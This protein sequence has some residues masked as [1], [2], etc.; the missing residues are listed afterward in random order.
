M[1]SRPRRSCRRATIAT[2]GRDGWIEEGRAKLDRLRPVAERAGLTPMQLACQW[3]L[4][5][6]A[7]ECAVPTLIQETGEG[8]RPIESK[9]SELAGLPAEQRLGPDQVGG[10]PVHR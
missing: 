5:H 10:D 8:A 2:S 7:V 6:P 3:N 4:A 9:R 1:T